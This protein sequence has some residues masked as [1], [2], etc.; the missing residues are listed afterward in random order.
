LSITDGQREQLRQRLLSERQ[1]Y[2]SRLEYLRGVSFSRDRTGTI[3]E[4]ADYDNHPA[5]HSSETYERESDFGLLLEARDHLRQLDAALL[6][7]DS[8]QY[9]RCAR[10]GAE[11]TFERLWARPAADLCVRCARRS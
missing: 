2:S 11:M 1:R 8:G 5:D 3:G 4:L 7:L 9:G 6:R 10:C